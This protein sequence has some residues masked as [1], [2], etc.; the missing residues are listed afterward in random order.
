MGNAEIH[1]VSWFGPEEVY[2]AEALG[3]PF[4][5]RD[6][7]RVT[8]SATL[9]DFWG[10]ADTIDMTFDLAVPEETYACR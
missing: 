8:G 3:S 4:I 10:T 2:G 5:H 7:D 1:K 6:E 9:K